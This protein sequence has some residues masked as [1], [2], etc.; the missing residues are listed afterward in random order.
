L[1][2]R[3]DGEG[4]AAFA[5]SPDGLSFRSTLLSALGRDLAFCNQHSA[6]R[7]FLRAAVERYPHDVWLRHDLVLSCKSLKPAAW[8]EALLHSAAASALCPECKLFQLR[9]AECSAALGSGDQA[10]A[11][12]ARWVESRPARGTSADAV[13][14]ARQS[15]VQEAEL[16]ADL[17]RMQGKWERVSTTE[18]GPGG[19]AARSVKEVRGDRETVTLY[20]KQGEVLHSHSVAITLARNGAAKTLTYSGMEILDGPGKGQKP[21]ETATYIYV[22]ANDT[23]YEANGLLEGRVTGTP[24]LGVWKRLSEK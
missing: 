10:D 22:L 14:A 20:G 9:V 18:G 2:D 13:T 12:Y 1:L 15:A 17:Q 19:D 16:K 6:C 11:A 23:I 8:A 24:S 5:A 21:A 4:L 3:G 7:T